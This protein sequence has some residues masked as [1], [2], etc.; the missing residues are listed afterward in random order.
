MSL[1]QGLL[2]PVLCAHR[3]ALSCAWRGAGCIALELQRCVYIPTLQ[4][5][6]CAYICVV[7]PVT[8]V[9]NPGLYYHALSCAV[10]AALVA[11][12][13]TLMYIMQR[14]S[15]KMVWTRWANM[16]G[17]WEAVGRQRIHPAFVDD[18]EEWN[19]L[20]CYSRGCV[21]IRHGLYWAAYANYNIGCP[22]SWVVTIINKIICPVLFP[23]VAIIVL[24]QMGM[25]ISQILL[26]S[27]V[28]WW[29]PISVNFLATLWNIFLG[30]YVRKEF[31]KAE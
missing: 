24:I 8:S 10:T 15:W 3:C 14:L 16:L 25:M 20:C 13:S 1:G 12:Q 11:T 9:R 5:I 18:L 31:E 26:I 6:L 4:G 17:Y 29:R 2:P 21:V 7:L 27:R 23:A 28:A 22:G 30:L 19:H